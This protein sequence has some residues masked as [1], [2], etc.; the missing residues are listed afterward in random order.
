MFIED[1]NEDEGIGADEEENKEYD[2][3]GTLE[4]TD[5]TNEYEDGADEEN[6]NFD[7]EFEVDVELT[8]VSAE[9][10]DNDEEF[11]DIPGIHEIDDS[12]EPLEEVCTFIIF[13]Y[14]ISI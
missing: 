14:Y 12:A 10:K 9:E 3:A 4:E 13:I 5:E 8:D 1:E 7:A 2:D 11:A 6:D